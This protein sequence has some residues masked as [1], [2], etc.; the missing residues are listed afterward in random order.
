[1][2]RI[3][4]LRRPWPIHDRAATR[5]IEQ[6]AQAALPPHTLIQRAGDA[7]ARL[8]LA[9]A[10]HAAQVWVAAGAGNNG[11]DGIAAALRLQQAGKAVAVTLLGEPAALPADAAAMHARALAAGIAFVAAPPPLGPDDLAIDALLGIGATRAPAGRFAACIDQLNALP[12]GVIAIDL[13]SG[14]N[15]DTG[16]PCGERVVRA[17]HTLSLLTLK[18]GLVTGQGR[19][20][21]GSLW[22]DPLGIESDEPP[23]ALLAGG[24]TLA[25]PAQA[26]R[27]AQHKGSFGDV[28]VVGGAPTMRGAALLAARAAHAAGAGRIYVSLLDAAAAA[29]DA[30]RPELMF[31][32][33]WWTR[34]APEIAVGTVVCGCGGGSVVRDALPALLAHA[35]RLVLDADA[36]NAVAA[37]IGLQS[38]L[39]SRAARERATVITPHPLEAARLLGLGNSRQ[40]QADRLGAV[41]ALVERYACVTVLKGSGTVIGGPQALPRINPTGSAALATAGTGDVLAGWIGGVWAQ[42]ATA[43]KETALLVATAS[44][45]CHGLAAD[46]AH[47]MPLR[48]ADLI[49]AMVRTR[50]DASASLAG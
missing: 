14:L 19:D 20:H 2:Q 43:S 44:V 41:A 36:L 12:C 47:R 46:Q 49:D 40:V 3:D 37:D 24:Q 34:P 22:I 48:A 23:Q 4:A 1:M 30:E 29:H 15:A 39:R 10:P 26:R 11:G 35:G 28:H 16:Q 33:A 42:H 50:D 7:V 27:H 8:A 6:R 38:Q 32:P 18:P 9:V 31:R 5:R 45:F 21:A 25:G 13:P 17:A